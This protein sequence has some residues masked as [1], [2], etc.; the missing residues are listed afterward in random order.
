MIILENLLKV[1]EDIKLILL[2]RNPIEV[3]NSWINAPKEFDENWDVNE[4]LVSAA[5]KNMGRKEN[6]YGLDAWV[7]TTRLFERLAKSYSKRVIL[8]DYSTLQSSTVQT[9]ENIFE[10]CDLEITH[11]THSFLKQ[12][13]EK[14]KS[15]TYSVFSGGTKSQTKPKSKS[16]WNQSKRRNTR[17]KQSSK[18]KDTKS[19]KTT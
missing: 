7:Q 2:V 10:F 4:Q 8:I 16:G 11:S 13:L 19:A 17:S 1:D 6:F 15:G 12:S 3:M 18:Y 14:E 5:L 9:V